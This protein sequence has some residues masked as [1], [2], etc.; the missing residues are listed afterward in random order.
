MPQ[1]GDAFIGVPSW[2]LVS[3]LWIDDPRVFLDFLNDALIVF[4]ASLFVSAPAEIAR[5]HYQSK[6]QKEVSRIRRFRFG[7]YE[8]FVKTFKGSAV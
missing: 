1:L 4:A 7:A 6:G 8:A 2:I 5:I 3:S